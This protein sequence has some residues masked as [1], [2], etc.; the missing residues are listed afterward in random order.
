MTQQT[1]N[2]LRQIAIR[3][4]LGWTMNPLLKHAF[5][6]CI[7]LL[8]LMFAPL[9]FIFFAGLFVVGVM[10]EGSL[11]SLRANWASNLPRDLLSARLK[12]TPATQEVRGVFIRQRRN[13]ALSCLNRSLN[14]SL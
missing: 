3:E 8:L 10:L 12:D 9:V 13:V 14:S 4:G 6:A 5:T 7:A 11:A 1:E 2:S